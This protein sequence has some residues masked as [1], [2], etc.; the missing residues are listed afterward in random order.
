MLDRFDWVE[1]SP[2]IARAQ[3]ERAFAAEGARLPPGVEVSGHSAA[4]PFYAG[5]RFFHLP[6]RRAGQ[7]PATL[8]FLADDTRVIV[9][10]GASAVIHELNGSGALECNL[11]TA[12]AYLRFFCFVVRGE[13]GPFAIL[14]PPVEPGPI[15]MAER[16]E[17]DARVVVHAQEI[18]HLGI[19]PE[20]R[21]LY[22]AIVAYGS[23]LFRAEFAVEPAG[24]IEMLED[25]EIQLDEDVSLPTWPPIFVVAPPAPLLPLTEAA[26]AA[27]R[28]ALS[29]QR[30]LVEAMLVH[31]LENEAGHRLLA[32]FNRTDPERSALE[33][34]ARLSA[35]ASPIVVIESTIPFVEEIVADI[36]T[37]HL[38]VDQRPRKVRGNADGHDDTRLRVDVPPQGLL[39]LSFHA[40]RSITDAERVS[41][42]L[43]SR[44]VA[45][46]FG[47]FDVLDV[48]EPLRR[49]AD[50]VLELPPLTPELFETVFE[51]TFGR[52]LPP[53]WKQ[54]GTH[55]VRQILHSDL[56]Q[57]HELKLAPEEALVFLRERVTER[58]RAVDPADALGLSDLH[59][60]AEARR[61][62][63]DLIADIHDAIA[64]RLPWHDVDRGVLLAGAPGTGK[65]T[66]ARA[67]ARDCRIKFVSA[68]AASWQAAGHLSDHIR[69]M[70]SDFAQARRFAPAILF[71]DE[72]DSIGSRE[73]VSGDNAQYHIEVVNALLEQM[74][75]MDPTAPVIV[76]AA[77]NHPDR[78][79]PALRRAG[80][81]D[82]MIE[83]PYPSIDALA[84]IFEHYLARYRHAGGV[85][86]DVDTRAL[87]SLAFGMTG[88]DVEMMVRGAARRARKARRPIAQLDL[89]AEVL[90][91]PRDPDAVPRLGPQE[92]GRVAAHEAGHALAA[93]LSSSGG[94]DIGFVS[95]VPRSDGS[96]GFVARVPS[97]RRIVT[98]A[99]MIERIEIML[100][101]RA[102]EELLFGDD[103]VSGGAG[104]PSTTSDLAAATQTALQLVSQTGL[105][106]NGS[107]LWSAR[108]RERHEEQAELILREAYISIRGRLAEHL[109]TL[110]AIGDALKQRQELTGEDVRALVATGGGPVATTKDAQ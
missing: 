85:A 46:L 96:L 65:T 7:P 11:D 34:F 77:T 68:S 32:H 33:A 56:E 18:Q 94:H 63:E 54:G 17:I 4:L 8:M 49:I 84:S 1:L 67:I 39:T 35:T 52:P 53:D 22:A 50:L 83:I 72:I 99:E 12:P 10:D 100:A 86:A 79:D 14:E 25:A 71:I 76:L 95:I 74:Q 26:P 62:A 45:A 60:L 105:A 19:D 103:G 108:P 28:G 106:P 15:A 61:F 89:F 24:M 73:L 58:M 109:P 91:M 78:I 48:P 43:T 104:G 36:I 30:V 98:R 5:F 82:R 29:V 16:P 80:R 51:R 2:E 57:P 90:G 55:W 31:A 107:L 3:A 92:I 23:G 64:G 70:R 101:G 41:Y 69:A 9:L 37:E 88:A 97:G 81:L 13:E 20:G 93:C 66:L 110:H 40:Y 47:C 42:E 21:L 87:G 6:L 59:G 75:G 27:A 102:A 38:P 44:N